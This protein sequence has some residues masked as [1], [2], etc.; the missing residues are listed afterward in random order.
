MDTKLF[1]TLF[2]FLLINTQAEQYGV[3]PSIKENV[4]P[5]IKENRSVHEKSLK[6]EISTLP[7]SQMDKLKVIIKGESKFYFQNHSDYNISSISYLVVVDDN[8]LNA[9][10]IEISSKRT[11]FNKL[12]S[13]EILENMYKTHKELNPGKNEI[14]YF[15]EK[16]CEIGFK[17]DWTPPNMFSEDVI[18]TVRLV[19]VKGKKLVEKGKKNKNRKKFRKQPSN[20]QKSGSGY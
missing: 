2:Y 4:T 10:G 19:E 16:E 12:M 3:T 1:L 5:S 18:V 20:K 17:Q 7:Y 9:D 13:T 8:L 15:E 6:K 11:S 14:Y